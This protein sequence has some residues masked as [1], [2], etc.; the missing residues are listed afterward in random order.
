MRIGASHRRYAKA[1]MAINAD[2]A[3]GRRLLDELRKAEDA[4]ESSSVLRD[5]LVSPLV[6]RTRKASLVREMAAYL[7]LGPVAARAWDLVVQRGRSDELPGILWQ[8]ERLLDDATGKTRADVR[9]AV[10]LDEAKRGRVKEAL[11]RVSGRDVICTYGVDPTLLGG[12]E[13]RV[14]N[15]LFDGSIRGRLERLRRDWLGD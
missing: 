7:H 1:L 4:V 9:S 11:D 14:G 8:L 10:L 15:R 3:A 13:A 2:A 12:L 5:I 6:D